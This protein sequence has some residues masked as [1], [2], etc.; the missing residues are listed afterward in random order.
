MHK[1][2][3]Q[4]GGLTLVEL[5]VVVAIM[6][7]L[8][9]LGI[10]TSG[11]VYKY[12][13]TQDC[14][15]N[16]MILVTKLEA[17]KTADFP[18]MDQP[19]KSWTAGS[20]DPQNHS[21]DGAPAKDYYDFR[22]LDEDSGKYVIESYPSGNYQDMS[23]G[24]R[25]LRYSYNFYNAP[26]EEVVFPSSGKEGCQIFVVYYKRGDALKTFDGTDTGKIAERNFVEVHCTLKEHNSEEALRVYFME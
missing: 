25:F 13:K 26:A 1:L 11:H 17:Y 10:P 21:W 9:A 23:E 6:G 4:K 24:E 19:N 22:A 14:K 16:Q 12:V 3:K 7:I 18:L 5:L 2:I 15:K 8:L 20:Y